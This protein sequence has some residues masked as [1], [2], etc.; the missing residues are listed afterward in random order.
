[1]ILIVIFVR[2][3]SHAGELKRNHLNISPKFLV[4]TDFN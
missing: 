3:G 1:M 2:C 4:K